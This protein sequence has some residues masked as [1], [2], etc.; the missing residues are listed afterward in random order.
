MSLPISNYTKQTYGQFGTRRNICILIK[1]SNS[2]FVYLFCVEQFL[3]FF[4][5]CLLWRRSHYAIVMS[6]SKS[7]CN[8]RIR[9]ST[10]FYPMLVFVSFW[11]FSVGRT[12]RRSVV[13]R[14]SIGSKRYRVFCAAEANNVFHESQK[15]LRV[16]DKYKQGFERILIFAELL[17]C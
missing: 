10:D 16:A 11:I 14:P 15:F 1:H 5:Y 17:R 2:F 4:G 9:I 7:E 12:C 13:G 6:E 3:R 8:N